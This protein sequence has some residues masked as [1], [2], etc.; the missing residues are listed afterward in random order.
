MEEL[1]LEI[2]WRKD[3]MRLLRNQLSFMPDH[4]KARFRKALVVMLY[5]HYEGFA[6][7][8]FTVYINAVNRKHLMCSEATLPLAAATLAQAF[9]DYENPSRKADEFRDL[10]PGDTELHRFGRQVWLLSTLDTLWEKEVAISA[11]QLVDTEANLMPGV[12]RKML[13]RLGF[14]YDAFRS[15]DGYIHRLLN[16]RN[17]I[18]HGLRKEGILE[19]DYDEIESASF[20]ILDGIRGL[21]IRQLENDAFLKKPE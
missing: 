17:A 19:A 18:A 15:H 16:H 6:K 10:F 9:K 8:A 21:V 11:E 20:A 4:D 12:L 13:F 3:E 5:S 7:A 1:E 14:E 2:T